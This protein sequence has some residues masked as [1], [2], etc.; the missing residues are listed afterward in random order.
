MPNAIIFFS[1]YKGSFNLA[2]V[3][4][5]M[6]AYVKL[7]TSLYKLLSAQKISTGRLMFRTDFP[8]S[9]FLPIFVNINLSTPFW[10]SI[11]FW[12]TKI[13]PPTLVSWIH[14]PF[15]IG[16]PLIGYCSIILF[17]GNVVNMYF[18]F[19]NELLIITNPC[20]SNYLLMPWTV[21]CLRFY[22]RYA[23]L[24]SISPFYSSM[25]EYLA[26][27]LIYCSCNYLLSDLFTMFECF[28][29]FYAPFYGFKGLIV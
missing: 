9:K 8:E 24:I 25:W 1:L 18:V 12:F 3:S 7:Y 16:C 14:S 15:Q 10:S 6:G 23:Y 26:T 21:I 11:F 28:Y 22:T 17:L 4:S 5:K 27:N 13:I 20:L 2:A 19:V 29:Y